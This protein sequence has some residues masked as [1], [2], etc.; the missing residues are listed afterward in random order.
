MIM[1]KY[2]KYGLI[3]LAAIIGLRIAI[4]VLGFAFNLFFAALPLI[5]LGAVIYFG[6]KHYDKKK[7]QAAAG[8]M[9][10]TDVNHRHH[11]GSN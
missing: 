1:N 6:K 7:A 10:Y 8:K 9:T 4:G 3:G 2:V 5:G 11:N